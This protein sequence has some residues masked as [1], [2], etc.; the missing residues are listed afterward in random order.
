MTA[1]LPA[2]NEIRIETDRLVMRP[3][4]PGD[5][6]PLAAILADWDVTKNLGFVPHP[7]S[8][9]DAAAWV[10][11]TPKQIAAGT[12]YPLAV[13]DKASGHMVAGA[14][15]DEMI[16]L[17]PSGR[18]YD[19]GYWFGRDHWGKGLATECAVGLRDWAFEEL[20]VGRLRA[21]CLQSNPGSAGVL[22]KAGFLYVNTEMRHRPARG[23]SALVECF[24]LDKPRWEALKNGREGAAA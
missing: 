12:D 22:E 10:A 13:L 17:G 20:R 6:A 19:F 23:I 7:F 2:M 24:R 4:A 1:D 14:G 9:S 15:L 16:D 5:E 8:L 3:L 18:E 21:S 11:V